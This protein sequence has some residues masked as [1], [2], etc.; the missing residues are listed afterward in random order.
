MSHMHNKLVMNILVILTSFTF[1]KSSY[2]NSSYSYT[3]STEVSESNS[4]ITAYLDSQSYSNILPIK[5]LIED[6]WKQAPSDDS[7]TGFT[8]NEVGIKAHW[9]NFYFNILSTSRLSLFYSN[10]ILYLFLNYRK[11]LVR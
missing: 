1:I 11:L 9:N 8:Q 3:D 5:Q 10:A 2:A 7:S 4:T 6:D